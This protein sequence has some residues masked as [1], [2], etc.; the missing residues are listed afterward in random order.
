MI[1][2]VTDIINIAAADLKCYPKH[3]RVGE[4]QR[5]PPF[6]RKHR[7]VG[8][9]QRNPPFSQNISRKDGGLRCAQPS[10]RN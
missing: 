5:N 4:A 10:L 1:I 3:R 6:S 2:F 8:E 9:A 7:R